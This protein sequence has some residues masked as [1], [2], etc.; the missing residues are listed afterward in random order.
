MSRPT[1][2]PA[3]YIALTAGEAAHASSD[4][5]AKSE[6]WNMLKLETFIMVRGK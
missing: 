2:P 1:L 5:S 4:A 3:L 6:P